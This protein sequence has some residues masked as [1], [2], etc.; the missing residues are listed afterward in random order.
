[1][2]V[3]EKERNRN[4]RFN[5][6]VILSNLLMDHD[7]VLIF[8]CIISSSQLASREV[9]VPSSADVFGRR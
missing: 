2:K 6:R 4:S 9:S 1:M 8:S 3:E 7:F 5:V